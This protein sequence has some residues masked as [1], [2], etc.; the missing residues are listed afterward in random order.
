MAR[1]HNIEA[2]RRAAAHLGITVQPVEIRSP[3][4]FEPAF[5]LIKRSRLQGLVLTQ[6]GLFYANMTRLAQLALDH[7]CR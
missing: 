5:A 2:A 1:V 6:D 4:D 7:N 3:A